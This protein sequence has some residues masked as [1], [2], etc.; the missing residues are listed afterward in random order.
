MN[1]PAGENGEELLERLGALLERLRRGELDARGQ[2]ELA[3]VLEADP[4]LRGIAQALEQQERQMESTLAAAT[5]HFDFEGARRAVEAKV[6]TDWRELR[7]VS[8]VMAVIVCLGLV[9]H[10]LRGK[11]DWENL[12]VLIGFSVPLLISVWWAVRSRARLRAMGGRVSA[13]RVYRQH[14]SAVRWKYRWLRWAIVV[15]ATV[16][17]LMVVVLVVGGKYWSAAWMLVPAGLMV[18]M[19]LHTWSAQWRDRI[20]AELTGR[21]SGWSAGKGPAR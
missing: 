21:P 8:A 17:V 13:E 15:S 4:G 9:S 14:V 1:A 6:Q 20:E 16:F 12:S 19:V 5:A 11:L 18:F 2:A 7:R 3:A 10:A